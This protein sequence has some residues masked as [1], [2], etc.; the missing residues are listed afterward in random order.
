M[1]I[2]SQLKLEVKRFLF[3][4]QHDANENCVSKLPRSSYRVNYIDQAI[5]V[6]GGNSGAIPT[7]MGLP[8]NLANWEGLLM[9]VNK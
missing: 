9:F 4:Y 6:L 2:L 5:M 8:L 7:G 1:C 3:L